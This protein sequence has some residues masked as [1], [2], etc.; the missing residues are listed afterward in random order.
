MGTARY[1]F[2]QGQSAKPQNAPSV[3]LVLVLVRRKELFNLK[4]IKDVEYV[5]LL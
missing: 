2:D 4:H 5:S 1:N 3:V